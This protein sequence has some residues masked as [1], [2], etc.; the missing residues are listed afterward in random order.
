LKW[1]CCQIGAR[2]HYAV[3]RALHRQGALDLLLTDAWVQPSSTLARIKPSSGS[4]FHADLARANVYAPNLANLAFE[5]RAQFDGLRSWDH[6]IARNEWFQRVGVARLRRIGSG[7]ASCTVMAYSYAALE[8]FKHARS[9][10]WRTVLGQI[11]P[12]PPE[13]RIVAK[14]YNENSNHSGEWQPPPSRYWSAWREEC[15]LADRV[16]VNSLW[17]QAALV[18]EGVPVE[19]IRLVP[20]AYERPAGPEFFQR[21]YPAAFT[22]SRPMRVLFLGQINLRKGILPLLDAIRLLRTEPIEFALVGPI[23][24]TIP[25]DLRCNHRVR[26]IGQVTRQEA[27]QFYQ[28]VD[29]FLFPTFSD[30]FGLTQLE[31]QAWKLP[32][33]AS[34]NC[35]QV[36][37]EGRNGWLLQEVTADA[38]A[39]VLRNC[40]SQPACLRK[41]SEQSGLEG[42]FNLDRVGEQWLRIF[43]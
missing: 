41:R 13:E 28:S 22:Q 11:D 30:G 29:I 31:A 42:Q 7:A 25:P 3:A 26:W 18:E 36:V 5:L 39:E 38:I 1:I 19:K 43:D 34:K 35:G 4:R 17:S 20:L 21:E 8:I 24:I 23:Q 9:R 2:E 12:G 40:C 37:Q 33:I 16:V 32:I 27:A 14:L 10:G 15:A 6:I